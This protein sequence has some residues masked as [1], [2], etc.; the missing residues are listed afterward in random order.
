[1]FKKAR[2]IAVL[3]AT[4]AFVLTGC[5]VQEGAETSDHYPRSHYAFEQELPDGRTVMCVWAQEDARSGGLSCDWAN[6]K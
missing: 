4:G 6:A 5:A 2:T 1:M 3:L